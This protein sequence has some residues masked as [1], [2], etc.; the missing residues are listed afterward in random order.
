[1]PDDVEVYPHYGDHGTV[2]TLVNLSKAEQS[3]SLP[4]ALNDVLAGGSKQSV[5]LPVCGVAV[6]EA[7]RP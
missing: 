5:T 3:V 7:P 1:V 4:S 2:F 6:L